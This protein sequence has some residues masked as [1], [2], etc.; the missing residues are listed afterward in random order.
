M[1]DDSALNEAELAAREPIEA[2]VAEPRRPPGEIAVVAVIAL[3]GVAGALARYQ[4]GLWW[5]TIP[6]GFPWTT[7]G[8]N[9]VGCALIGVLMMLV[10]DVFTVHRLVRPLLGTGVLGGFTTF[11][12]YAV[13]SQHLIAT[14]HAG[15]GLA[16][17]GLTVLV[18]IVAVTAGARL[19]RWS[20]MVAQR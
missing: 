3:G 11:S 15:L 19:A 8:I 1:D 10:V 14:G 4:A 12:T 13:D 7:L 5:P 16:N 18:A 2:D 20:V 9:G 6:G 17:V